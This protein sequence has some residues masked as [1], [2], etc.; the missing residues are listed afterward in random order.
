MWVQREGNVQT[1]KPSPA[2]EMPFTDHLEELRWRI[3][4]SL[5]AV[6]VATGI[7]Y[8]VVTR[9]D[10]LGILIRPIEPFLHGGKLK[11]LHPMDPFMITL[12]LSIVVGLLLASPLLAQQIWGFFSPALEPRERRLI[13][14]SFALGLVLFA[15]GIGIG[16]YVVLPLSLSF[17]MGYQTA[18]LEQAIVAGE[19]ISFVT[20]L[21]LAFGAVFELPV[22]IFILAGLGLVTPRFLVEKRR[23]AIVGITIIAAVITPGDTVTLTAFLAIPMVILYEMSIYLARLAVRGRGRPVAAAARG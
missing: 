17:A 6:A 22:V 5:L 14:P 20:D 8:L 21:L 23:H 10:V 11:Y 16:Y 7:G 9:Y 12:K 15:L 2:R 4:W 18:S 1:P 13:V 3:I 19:Y